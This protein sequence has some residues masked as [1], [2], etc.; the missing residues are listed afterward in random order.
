MVENLN[1]YFGRAMLPLIDEIEQCSEQWE[2]DQ[3]VLKETDDIMADIE[4]GILYYLEMLSI[5][6]PG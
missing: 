6:M 2:L 3:R 5:K 4:N 1:G